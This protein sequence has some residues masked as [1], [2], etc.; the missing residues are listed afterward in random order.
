MWATRMRPV[1]LVT[2]PVAIAVPIPVPIPVS[3][4]MAVTM[5]MAVPVTMAVAAAVVSLARAAAS[6]SGA[7]L[8]TR[9]R[10]MRGDL[11]CD[12]CISG[13][14][15]GG[16]AAKASRHTCGNNRYHQGIFDQI[17]SGLIQEGSGCV[18]FVL[19][20]P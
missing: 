18:P 20:Q 17:L 4:A 7:G 11:R 6:A 12:V 15:A 3:I 5:A 1:T 2:L 10:D 14:Y 9:A 19:K 16:D 13:A 8:G